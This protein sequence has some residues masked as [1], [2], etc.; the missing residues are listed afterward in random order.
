MSRLTHDTIV[1]FIEDI[2]ERKGADSYLGEEVTM[3]QHMLQA[4]CLA[5]EA[6]ADDE[7]I[8]AALLHDIGHYTNEFL[9]NYIEQGVD[10]FHESA[11]AIILER[12]FPDR[13]VDCVRYHVAAKRYL[14]A[15]DGDYHEGLSQASKQ[16]LKLQGGSMSPS[17]AQTFSGK[18]YLEDIIRVRRWDDLGKSPSKCT[19]P[20]SHYRPVL[21]KI[22]RDHADATGEA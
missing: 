19:P 21:E 4:A 14:C 9:E 15:T 12:F 3:L 13:V 17:D 1:A 6:G 2:L 11:G 22:V 20:F 10:N 18:V 8:C 16:T 5:E 7:L